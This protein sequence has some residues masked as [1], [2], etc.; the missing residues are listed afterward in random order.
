MHEV[1][2]T[3]HEARVAALT[4]EIEQL[5]SAAEADLRNQLAAQSRDHKQL[6][7]ET[8]GADTAM[9][10]ELRDRI[11]QLE[12][13][14]TAAK[15]STAGKGKSNSADH[16]RKLKQ[17]AEQITA[18]AEHL[19]RRRARLDK[20]RRLLVQKQVH[21]DIEQRES[22]AEESKSIFEQNQRITEARRALAEAEK[23]MVRRWARPRAVA[24]MAWIVILAVICAGTS[25]L[26][27]GQ[28]FPPVVA[29]SAVLEARNTSRSPL[30]EEEA[31]QWKVWH[32]GLFSDA[33]FMQT[34]SKRLAER[35]I[36]A[37]AQP[38]TISK[39]LSDNLTV[40]AS[41]KGAM[42][43]TLAGENEDETAALL[44]VVAAT[45]AAESFRTHGNR[46]DGAWATLSGERNE[47]GRLKWATINASPI[48][49]ERMKAAGPIFGATF[50]VCLGLI[51]VVY[52][53]LS[54]SKRVFEQDNAGLF[55]NAR[56]SAA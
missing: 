7:A 1:L 51:A 35:R 5:K 29:A 44:D 18:V 8:H 54:K 52:T 12:S 10:A 37:Y 19:R 6:L 56:I 3:Q 17:K 21:G 28:V 32:Q 47:G 40:D 24:T 22:T 33:T 50:A 23:E 38:A 16:S 2:V 26:I 42:I 39:R 4:N 30:T 45:V 43:L 41:Q 53:R 46:H 25:W 31:N 11:E 34:L 9:V 36:D 13:E 15:A 27:A 48:K 20:V 49:D 14:L 55:T